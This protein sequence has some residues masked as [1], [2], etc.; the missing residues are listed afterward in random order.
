[1][2]LCVSLNAAS[3][4]MAYTITETCHYVSVLKQHLKEWHITLQKHVIICQS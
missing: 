1:M 4:K 2:S 3:E